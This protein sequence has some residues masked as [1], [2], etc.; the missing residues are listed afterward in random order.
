MI[1]GGAGA[2]KLEIDQP[3]AVTYVG[4][5]GFFRQISQVYGGWLFMLVP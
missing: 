5:D 3:A 1:V 2:G 4:D